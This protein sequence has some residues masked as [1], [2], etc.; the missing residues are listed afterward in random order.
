MQ[1]PCWY[2]NPVIWSA[3]TLFFLRKWLWVGLVPLLALILAISVWSPFSQSSYLIG[4]WLWVAS[5]P[6]VAGSGVYAWWQERRVRL[7][8]G[9]PSLLV[10]V[11]LARR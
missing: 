3:C 6:V 2:A 9:V 10:P 4:Y 5:L 8:T 11:T 7:L 1:Y